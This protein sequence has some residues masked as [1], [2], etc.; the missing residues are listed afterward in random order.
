MIKNFLKRRKE[1]TGSVTGISF[2]PAPHR[3]V[4][5]TSGLCCARGTVVNMLSSFAYS[6]F[7]LN[8]GPIA[9]GD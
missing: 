9:P 3:A 1:P 7:E 4:D 8:G 6:G 2:N 5:Y